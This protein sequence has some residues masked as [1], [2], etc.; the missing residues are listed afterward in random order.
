VSPKR[1][2]MR[3]KGLRVKNKMT[4]ESLAKKVKIS[5]VHLANIESPDN[6]PHHRAPSLAVLERLAK[7]L[8]VPVTELLE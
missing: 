4:Q 8:G 7:A 1:I 3:I 6:A 5:R 2:G